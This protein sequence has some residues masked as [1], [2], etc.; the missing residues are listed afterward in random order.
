MTSEQHFWVVIGGIS[1]I[2]AI[3]SF[4]G[5]S[6]LRVANKLNDTLDDLKALKSEVLPTDGLTLRAE[7]SLIRSQ[8]Y[9]NG[10]TSLRDQT[11]RIEK[12]QA[13]IKTQVDGIE[14]KVDTVST[15]LDNHI[16]RTDRTH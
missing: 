9:T 7:V 13:A 11:N 16:D 5:R 8:V 14:K 4:V 12:N 2:L 10:G 15:R 6:L 3:L 1:A